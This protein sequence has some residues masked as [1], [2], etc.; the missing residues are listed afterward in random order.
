MDLLI[1]KLGGGGRALPPAIAALGKI[2][3]RL[4]WNKII[5]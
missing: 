1:L 3:D 4:R 5:L 2:T